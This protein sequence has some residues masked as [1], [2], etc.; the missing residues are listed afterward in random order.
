[1]NAEPEV[2]RKHEQRRRLQGLY[3]ACVL[4]WAGLVFAADSVGWLPKVGSADPWNWVFFGAGL[5]ALL[6]A[7]WREV[8]PAYARPRVGNYVWAGVLIII[9]LSAVI[10]LKITWP[11]VLL[12]VGLVLLANFLFRR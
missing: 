1:M 2:A 4:I 10:A 11:L 7:L 3:W 9:G 5:L 8:S 12:V 6:G